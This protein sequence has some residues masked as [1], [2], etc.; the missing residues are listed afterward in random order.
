MGLEENINRAKAILFLILFL[1]IGW[2]IITQTWKTIDTINDTTI[3]IIVQIAILIAYLIA[4]FLIPFLVSQGYPIK[5]KQTLY[6]IIYLLII[7]IL[8]R[9]LI[10]IPMIV[11]NAL[12]TEFKTSIGYTGIILA[13]TIIVI[14]SLFGIPILIMLGDD[15]QWKPKDITLQ[16]GQTTTK[17]Q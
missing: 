5:M 2:T 3:R 8:T 4:A 12:P 6:G 1:F 11:A 15:E 7:P 17:A 10:E 16:D 9:I 13:L 14:F